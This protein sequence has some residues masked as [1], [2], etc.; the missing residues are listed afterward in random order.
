MNFSA[1]EITSFAEYPNMAYKGL[2]LQLDGG[3]GSTEEA[4]HMLAACGEPTIDM[5]RVLDWQKPSYTA[6]SCEVRPCVKTYSDPIHNSQ[7]K[8]EVIDEHMFS[9]NPSNGYYRAADLHCISE[10]Q[11]QDILNMGYNIIA[12][13]RWTTWHVAVDRNETTQQIEFEG[14][15]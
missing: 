5:I 9:R 2:T 7:L 15:C 3:T 6:Y 4:R 13:Q 10:T 1:D 12:D 14:T 8:E 11:R